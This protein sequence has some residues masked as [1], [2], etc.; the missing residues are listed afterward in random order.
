MSENIIEEKIICEEC[1]SDN[2]MKG[3]C[4][5][6]G[7]E[8]DKDYVNPRRR[9]YNAHTPIHDL[10]STNAVSDSILG[11]TT[12]FKAD[13]T[14][15]QNPKTKY[16]FL[17]LQKLNNQIKLISD[18]D[19]RKITAQTK[20]IMMDIAGYC[21]SLNVST[22]FDIVDD[23]LH[24]FLK[25]NKKAKIEGIALLQPYIAAA[26]IYT[27]MKEH[28]PLFR[29]QDL[30]RDFRPTSNLQSRFVTRAISELRIKYKR[31]IAKQY[32]ECGLPMIAEYYGFKT[33]EERWQ[34][35]YR[36][37]ENMK[38]LYKIVGVGGEDENILMTAILY[39]ALQIEAV[40]RG[41]KIPRSCSMGRISER[42]DQNKHVVR[43]LYA[44]KIE[45]HVKKWSKRVCENG[46]KQNRN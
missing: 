10:V 34:F 39:G 2:I 6:C 42:F 38:T 9:N 12:I 26:S 43:L 8:N 36:L 4:R 29:L 18:S 35:S 22:N 20:L 24:R 14:R 37:R 31:P 25:Y 45:D 7:L 17:R 11:G 30:C 32:I 40:N 3:V 15:L 41:T 44:R 21:R 27:V 28:N 23:I 1:G 33:N 19:G 13:I 16:Q 5:D 46:K